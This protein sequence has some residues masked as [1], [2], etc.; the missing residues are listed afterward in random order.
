VSGWWLVPVSFA[1]MWCQD[2]VSVIMVRAEGTGNGHRAGL[3]DMAQDACGLTGQ[4]VGLGAILL[5]HDL[6][7]SAA[8]IAARLAADYTG[9]RSGVRLGKRLD[10]RGAP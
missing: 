1:A 3:C 6:V 8:V 5:G 7:L 9:T 10:H 4:A 2:V